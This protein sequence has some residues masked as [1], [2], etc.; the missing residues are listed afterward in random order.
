MKVKEYIESG[1]LEAFVLGLTKEEENQKILTLYDEHKEI[2]E[3]IE[4]IEIALEA[5]SNLHAVRV[6]HE[7]RKSIFNSIETEE[8]LPPLLTSISK[9]S[10]YQYWLDRFEFDGP[11]DFEGIYRKLIAD[12]EEFALSVAW[13]R[14]SE[15]DHLHTDYTEK[16]LIVEGSCRA[17]VDGKSTAYTVGDYVEFPLGVAHTYE[18]TSDTPMKIL[19]CFDYK[20]AA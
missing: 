7:L 6:P 13:F 5:Y 8:I 17:I 16:L 18:I 1:I 10:D 20:A 12:S 2:R 15:I 19:I 3:E 14:G 4:A 11:S 9:I